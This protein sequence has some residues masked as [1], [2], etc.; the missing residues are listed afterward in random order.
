MVATVRE[1]EVF[2][3]RDPDS[4]WPVGILAAPAV[5]GLK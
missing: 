4:F 1:I 3:T 5:P 2:F